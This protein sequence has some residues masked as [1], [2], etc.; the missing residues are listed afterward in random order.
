MESLLHWAIFERS[1]KLDNIIWAWNEN[2]FYF[3]SSLL[4]LNIVLTYII[5]FAFQNV[6]VRIKYIILYINVLFTSSP[7]NKHLFLSA[8]HCALAS[9]KQR[10]I[11]RSMSLTARFSSLGETFGLFY[12]SL[13]HFN[14][15]ESKT[16]HYMHK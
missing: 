8:K 15:L 2:F 9:E 10:R 11:K 7:L 14:L 5:F 13:L 1:L 16:W 6:C 3:H 12:F 4:F